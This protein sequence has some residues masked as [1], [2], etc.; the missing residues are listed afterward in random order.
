MTM[1][2]EKYPTDDQIAIQRYLRNS[3]RQLIRAVPS[4]DGKEMIIMHVPATAE[5]KRLPPIQRYRG[6]A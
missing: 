3:D 1:T 5:A 6:R 2:V 4:K